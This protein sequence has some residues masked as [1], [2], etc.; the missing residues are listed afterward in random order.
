[1]WFCGGH[2]VCLTGAG[3]AG[4][5]EAA[6]VAW[7][8]RY[9]ARTASVD[10][11]PRFEWLADDAQWRSAADYP[12]AAGTPI[13]ATGDGHARAQP[14]RRRSPARSPPPAAP[15]TPST[16]RSR[17]P[18]PPPRSSASRS[19]SSP[20]A[21][22][23]PRRPRTSSPRSSTRRAAS[24]SATRPRRSR[25]RSTASRTRSAARWRRSPPPRPPARSYTLQLTGGTQLYGPVRGAAAITFS[26]RRAAAADRRR[27]SGGQRRRRACSR[28]RARASRAG[29]FSI[30]VRG[31]QP[32]VT[33]AGK[34]VKVRRGRAV[35]DLRG[36]PK[37]TVKVKVVAQAQG[38]DRARDARTLPRR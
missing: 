33:V 20:T 16:C 10:T 32:R 23:A 37:G 21:A 11:G 6:V 14:R 38:Q 4:H 13:T 30:R 3:P 1:M 29:T 17:R 2:G 12:V 25:S 19:S 24:S 22:P 7:L 35:I 18:A 27:A 34:R 9:V 28:P 26:A 36:R 15:S 8:K 5:I 31:A